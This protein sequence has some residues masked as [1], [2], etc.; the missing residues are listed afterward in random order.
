MLR[1]TLIIKFPLVFWQWC[2]IWQ[3]EHLADE[4]LCM[5]SPNVLCQN[6]WRNVTRG[7][8]CC[9]GFSWIWLLKPEVVVL[10]CWHRTDKNRPILLANTVVWRKSSS[11]L[12]TGQFFLAGRCWFA[13]KHCLVLSASFVLQMQHCDLLIAWPTVKMAAK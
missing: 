12:F 3:E 2:L 10:R 5:L 8:Q 7:E 4:N 9:H 13:V 6:M 11:V 1:L